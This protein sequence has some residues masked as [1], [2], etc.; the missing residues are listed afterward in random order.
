MI[1]RWRRAAAAAAADVGDAG[2]DVEDLPA[3]GEGGE[4]EDVAFRD[5]PAR[6]GSWLSDPVLAVLTGLR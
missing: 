6:A 5:S 4:P 3:V 2:G 1:G